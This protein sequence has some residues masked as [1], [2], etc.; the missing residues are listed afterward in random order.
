LQEFVWN[1]QNPGGIRI[2]VWKTRIMLK[3]L[4][5]TV[6]EKVIE[7]AKLY[8]RDTGRSLSDMI[9]GYLEKLVA[10]EPETEKHSSRVKKLVGV[11]KLPKNFDEK[12]EIAEYLRKK[13][14]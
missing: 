7:K 2:F 11:V 13:H 8:A 14:L 1:L 5:L 3:K 6:D 10:Q 9:E 12:K 4:T